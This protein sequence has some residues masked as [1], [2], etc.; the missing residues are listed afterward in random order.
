MI[1]FRGL[2]LLGVWYVIY[3]LETNFFFD[4]HH[5]A[6]EYCITLKNI[7][8]DNFDLY[9]EHPLYIATLAIFAIMAYG[10]GKA[11]DSTFGIFSVLGITSVASYFFFF[12]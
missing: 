7:L 3:V 12:S 10:L 2:A 4:L 1:L 6:E 9:I 11:F 5:H 8:L